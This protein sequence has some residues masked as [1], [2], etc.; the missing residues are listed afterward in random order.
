MERITQISTGEDVLAQF[1]KVLA[2]PAGQAVVIV[3]PPKSGKSSLLTMLL[4]AAREQ[5]HIVR[6]AVFGPRNNPSEIL[7]ALAGERAGSITD[8]E[9]FWKHLYGQAREIG[10]GQRIV[11]GV[12]ADKNLPKDYASLWLDIVEKLPDQVKMV[13]AQRPRDILARHKAFMK[14]SNVVRIAIEK[15]IAPS[16][17]AAQKTTEEPAAETPSAAPAEQQAASDP[18]EDVSQKTV[19]EPVTEMQSTP[20]AEQEAPP[21]RFEPLYGLLGPTARVLLQRAATLAKKQSQGT[22]PLTTSALLF[23]MVESGRSRARQYNTAK[24]LRDLLMKRASET[25][26]TEVRT[27]YFE[28]RRAEPYAWSLIPTERFGDVASYVLEVLALAGQVA[29]ETTEET[30]IHVRHLLAALLLFRSEEGES[31]A[32]GVLRALNTP[33]DW[34]LE[35][36]RGHVRQFEQDK[37][38]VWERILGTSA[39]PSPEAPVPLPE[40]LALMNNDRLR[41]S[42]NRLLDRLNVENEVNAISAIVA[43]EKTDPPLSIGLFGDWGSGKSFFMDMMYDRIKAIGQA[44]RAR[45]QAKQQTAFCTDI[46]QIQ[47][48]AWHYTDA[49]LWASLVTHIFDELAR[50]ISEKT[51]ETPERTKERLLQK[52]ELTGEQL[53]EAKAKKERAE[54]LKTEAHA[55]LDI[56]TD[57]RE[58]A[59][60]TLDTIRAEDL[61]TLAKED[62]Q[63]QIQLEDVAKRLGLPQ[64]KATFDE[65]EQAV[66]ESRRVFGRITRIAKDIASQEAGRRKLALLAALLAVLPIG[67]GLIVHAAIPADWWNRLGALIAT[68]V[69]FLGAFAKTLG[70]K[71]NDISAGLD[72]WEKTR[73]KVQEV[74]AKKSR[75]ELELQ[76]HIRK[77]ENLE[78]EAR[79]EV[80][81]AEKRFQEAQEELDEVRTGRRL[82]RFIEERSRRTEYQEQLGIITVIRKDF[83]GLRD[84]IAESA[85]SPAAE[86]EEAEGSDET[87]SATE[88]KEARID[89]IVLY[90]DDLDRCPSERVIE[91]LQAVHLLLAFELFVVVVG[92]DSRWILH[93]LREQYAAFGGDGATVGLGRRWL[94]TPQN[95]VEKIFQIP[96]ALRPM[97]EDGYMR[98]IEGLTAGQRKAV[99]QT[100]DTENSADT[101]ES[102][103]PQPEPDKEHEEQDAVDPSQAAKDDN[104]DQKQRVDSDTPTPEGD[105][106]EAQEK[107][108]AIAM[109][110]AS[111]ELLPE[112]IAFMQKLGDLV[113]SPRAAKRLVNVY[114]L[115]RATIQDDRELARLEGRSRQPGDYEA[116]L[117]MLAILTGFP[118]QAIGMLKTLTAPGPK[119]SGLT[120]FLGNL[121]T[122]KIPN[123]SPPAYSNIVHHRISATE[124]A[125]WDSLSE[126]LD[127]QRQELKLDDSLDP[128]MYWAERVARFS[129]QYAQTLL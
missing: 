23:A 19:E 87:G 79:Q 50:A 109:Q 117:F 74:A 107:E 121:K 89:R 3:G 31:G 46:V 64:A 77:L 65:V 11:I 76:G 18:S 27:H 126:R 82:Y 113:P 30:K 55:A 24:F 114:R 36:F 71:M 69:T 83:E 60:K 38:E 53:R 54:T 111:L 75:E 37:P 78:A 44:S 122:K 28:T 6:E 15:P 39:A 90:I 29:R 32:A 21:E 115:I 95:Y 48:N 91:V 12:D 73:D 102:L 20:L 99:P 17:D 49:N 101:T 41:D 7:S 125:R 123:S 57:Q 56:L 92:V 35:A 34:V 68:G 72:A 100:P 127:A 98:F 105:S 22:V 104:A 16:E 116:V 14:L 80:L 97:E 93:A 4:G 112:E 124:R 1:N 81:E 84:L 61:I 66:R 58:A 5:S 40:A 45:V 42:Q 86:A 62:K 70:P 26:I 128:Y 88:V 103:E 8:V 118:T 106:G 67:V 9:T 120:D 10:K 43:A 13:F 110:P 47:F 59:A 96:F 108:S 85:M 25:E 52:A 119:A 51:R 33:A 63:V 2:D 129:F 94:T